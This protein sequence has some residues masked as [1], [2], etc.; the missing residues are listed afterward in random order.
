[1]YSASTFQVA[2]MVERLAYKQEVASLNLANGT[3]FLLNP[4]ILAASA[5]ARSVLLHRCVC[6]SIEHCITRLRI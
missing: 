2:Q 4:G 6:A 5:L 3:H 1:M